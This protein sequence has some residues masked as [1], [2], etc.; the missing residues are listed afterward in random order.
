MKITIT[1]TE[2]PGQHSDIAD[3]Y[4]IP[5]GP[6]QYVKGTPE[7]CDKHDRNYP[8]GSNCLGCLQE[9]AEKRLKDLVRTMD[10]A[11][12]DAGNSTTVFGNDTKIVSPLMDPGYYSEKE[13]NL[14]GSKLTREAID[15]QSRRTFYMVRFGFA[16]AE[17][18]EANNLIHCT[19]HGSIGG[20][21]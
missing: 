14:L 8:A 11:H 18:R 3:T 16:T 5:F 2:N 20:M 1:E 7:H 12:K 21:Y 6:K 17:Y 15:D 9:A 13:M 4:E 10:K 19:S